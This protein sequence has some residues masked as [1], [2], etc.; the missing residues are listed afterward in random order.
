M[1]KTPSEPKV[2]SRLSGEAM[3]LIPFFKHGPMVTLHVACNDADTGIFH[4]KADAVEICYGGS[5]DDRL[6][7]SS[8]YF[9]WSPRFRCDWKKCLYIGGRRIAYTTTRSHVGNWCWDSFKISREDA[10]A[11]IT[12][13]KFRKWFS[14]DEAP[15][16]LWEAYQPSRTVETPFGKWHYDA[17]GNPVD[18]PV[19]PTPDMNSPEDGSSHNAEQATQS[20]E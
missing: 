13:S 11:L 12:W 19:T 10:A 6:S 1:K 18:Q 9:D 8:N 3:K 15:T 2:Y 16:D 14:L 5:L 17:K 4:G 20:A 7:F